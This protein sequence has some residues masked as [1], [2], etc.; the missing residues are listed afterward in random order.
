MTDV[1]VVGGGLAG[2]FTAVE[3]ER[4]GLDF[5]VLEA[6]PRPGGVAQ[7]LTEDGFS[8]EAAAGTLLL[9][10]RHLSPLLERAG[11]EVTPAAPAAAMRYVYTRDRLVAVPAS[12]RA[13]FAPVVSPAAKARAV[14]EP[15]IRSRT[16]PP[17]ESLNHF[18][19]RRLGT[20]TGGLLAG[21]MA[22]GVFAGD[23]ARLSARSAFPAIPALEDDAGS[24]VMGAL[25]RLRHRPAGAT[26]PTSHLA[27]G[28]MSQMATRLAGHLGD[29]LLT[30]FPVESVRR[31]DDGLVVEGRETLRARRVV[32]ALAPHQAAAVLGGEPARLLKRTVT[33]PVAVVGLG[34]RSD[35]VRL[36]AGFGYLAG[37]DT[38]LVGI[39]CLFESSYAPDRAPV[40]GSLVKIIAGGARRPDVVEWDDTRLVTRLG[41]EVA[42]V[43]GV[44]LDAGM[45]RVVRHLPGIPQY[46][47]G[48]GDWLETVESLL[49]AGVTLTGWGYRGV[50]VAHLAGDAVRVAD[51]VAADS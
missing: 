34:S 5:L 4:R 18:M 31:D 22:G 3:L 29:R 27:V 14:L 38:D 50:G 6:S 46:E 16:I 33:A 26:R 41:E 37:P 19:R 47:V 35:G 44:D 32:L 11:V 28:G 24:I 17:D 2:L 42:K 7:T 43:S 25:R 1:I 30:S 23:P 10:H 15:F 9:P 49:P 13:L 45:V 39:G 40:G 48:H 51:S 8:L 36:P 21:I 20:S 12:P